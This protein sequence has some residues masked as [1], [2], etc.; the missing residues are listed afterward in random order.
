MTS[1]TKDDKPELAQPIW[2]DYTVPSLAGVHGHIEF[3]GPR[4]GCH[5]A[6]DDGKVKLTPEGGKADCRIESDSPGELL[7][8]VRGEL[9]VVTAVLQGRVEASGDLM[10]A[11]KVAGSLP[12]LGKQAVAPAAQGGA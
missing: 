4:G 7:R 2:G 9:N 5:M 3:A 10:L 11:L 1:S 8:L 12:E 6:I